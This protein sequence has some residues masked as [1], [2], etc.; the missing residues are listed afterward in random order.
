MPSAR[1][2][3]CIFFYQGHMFL[4]GLE[5]VPIHD[6]RALEVFNPNVKHLIPFVQSHF[7]S[8][9]IDCLFSVLHWKQGD[10]LSY[11][12]KVGSWYYICEVLWKDLLV[13]VRKINICFG[14]SGL[15][16]NMLGLNDVQLH[17]QWTKCDFRVSDYIEAMFGLEKGTCGML[18]TVTDATVTIL[19]TDC[20]DMS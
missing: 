8:P 20:T 4:W 11:G 17:L 16:S 14:D 10:R 19:K 2:G 9:R 12:N 18:T 7:D 3:E 15:D 6:N 13:I 1:E 5:L